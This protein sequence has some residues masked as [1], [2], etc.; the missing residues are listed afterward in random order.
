MPSFSAKSSPLVVLVTYPNA[1]LLDVAGP[2]Q[3]FADARM[4]GG[5]HYQTVIVSLEGGDQSTDTSVSLPS[6]PFD[7]LGGEPIHTLLIAGGLGARPASG[8]ARLVENVTRLAHRANRVASICTGAYILAATGLLKGCRAV[9]H[10]GFCDDLAKKHPEVI[11]EPDR[12]FIQ[13]GNVW[14]SA[15]VTA[16]LDMALAMIAEDSGRKVAVSLAREMVAYM[17]RPGGQT[18]FSTILKSQVNDVSGTFDELHAWISDNLHEDL[19]VEQLAQQA[20]M[21]S[22]NFA[23]LYRSET[24][25]TPAK[26]VELFRVMAA[27]DRLEDSEDSIT[28]IAIKT[29][30]VDDERLR[31]AMQRVLGIS[32]KEYRER[33][34]SGDN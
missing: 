13:Q 17:V 3:V 16:G 21:S 33:F 1:K 25:Y 9:T 22:R 15:G 26:A 2:L 32:P 19:C 30:F 12:I 4:R 28:A 20:G 31:R 27:R 29:G 11:I 7:A 23:R 10:W 6:I 24:G 18:Q 5:E 34:G 14:T 8:D